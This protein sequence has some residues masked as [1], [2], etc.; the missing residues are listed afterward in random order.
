MIKVICVALFLDGY[1]LIMQVSILF[2]LFPVNVNRF[3]NFEE[4]KKFESMKERE[5]MKTA[6]GGDS[7]S[8]HTTE[9]IPV[10]T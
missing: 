5:A 8:H 4:I 3:K 2:S 7:V 10:S 9:H 1:F 6:K